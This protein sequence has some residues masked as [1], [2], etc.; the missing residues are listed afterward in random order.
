MR[1]AREAVAAT[2]LCVTIAGCGSSSHHTAAF[3]SS[4]LN[5][6]APIVLIGADMAHAIEHAGHQTPA[7]VASV[8]TGI[9]DRFQIQLI[10]LEALNP[11][12]SVAGN[13][14]K[15]TAAA[16]RLEDDLRAISAGASHRNGVAARAAILALVNDAN[17]MNAPAGAI[18]HQ[19]GIK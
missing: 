1:G 16:N 7:K 18:R 4:Y 13:F 10:A 19:L 2:L 3:K 12:A 9:A 14:G 8:F 17:A 5:A 11:P 6:T 15:L